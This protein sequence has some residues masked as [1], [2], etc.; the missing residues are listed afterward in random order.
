[1]NTQ[2]AIKQRR[3]IKQFDP[4][5]EMPGATENEILSLAMLSPTA[6]NIQ[7][8][9]F[10]VVKDGALREQIKQAAWGQAQVTDSSLLVILCADLKAWE[11]KPE[12]YWANASQNVRETMLPMIDGYYRDKAQVQRDEAMR[13]CGIAAQT[14]MLAAK[15]MG[16][17]SCP[18]DGFDFDK[19]GELINLPDDHVVTMFVAIG[20]AAGDAYPRGGQL[21]M[22]DIVI[23]DRF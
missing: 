6:Y 4:A 19:V 18:M 2:D 14:L 3:A 10:V 11:K 13:S 23:N 21:D 16:Y 15:A 7:N 8:W 5:H 17:D 22:A 1:M 12:R 20:K 9:R